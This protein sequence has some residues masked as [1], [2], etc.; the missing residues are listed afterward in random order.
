LIRRPSLFYLGLGVYALIFLIVFPKWTVDDAYITFRYARNLAE[1]GQ[2]TW[3][4]G[5]SPVEGYTGIVLPLILALA[6]KLGISP[7]FVS[8][9]LGVIGF[10]GASVLLYLLLRELNIRSGVR[11]LILLLYVTSPF[12]YTHAYSG[13][14]TNLFSAAL[15]ACLYASFVYVRQRTHLPAVLGLFVLTSMIR[16]EGVLFTGLLIVGIGWKLPQRKLYM[17][18]VA[19]VVCS[20]QPAVSGVESSLLRVCTP[21]YVL[22]QIL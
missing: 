16:P 18:D 12:V 13:L 9:A 2:L 15:A 17:V 10:L 21:Q 22:R 7:F 3:N 6:F 5:E 11:K 8:H 14:E 4:V 19:L 20:T 1:H